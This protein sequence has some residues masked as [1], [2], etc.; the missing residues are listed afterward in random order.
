LQSWRTCKWKA[1]RALTGTLSPQNDS[2]ADQIEGGKRKEARAAK[3]KITK[4]LTFL[5]AW[6]TTRG[7]GRDFAQTPFGYVC[8]RKALPKEH[9]FFREIDEDEA[10]RSR[11]QHALAADST[12]A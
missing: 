4:L 2:P 7:R 6:L 8:A 10:S 9:P 1:W 12:A 3:L 11:M 5:H